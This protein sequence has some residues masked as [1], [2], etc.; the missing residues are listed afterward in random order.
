MTPIHHRPTPPGRWSDVHTTEQDHDQD[1]VVGDPGTAAARLDTQRADTW[2]PRGR[3]DVCSTPAGG[4]TPI[5]GRRPARARAVHGLGTSS[6]HPGRTDSDARFSRAARAGR[7]G[8]RSSSQDRRRRRVAH[9]TT[10]RELPTPPHGLTD[11]HTDHPAAPARADRPTAGT[12]TQGGKRRNDPGA[13]RP[14]EG[15]SPRCS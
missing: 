1:H 4:G 13:D 15:F 12:P 8:A 9:H 7:D 5:G 11:T 2:Y 14:R 6:L 10:R 3:P